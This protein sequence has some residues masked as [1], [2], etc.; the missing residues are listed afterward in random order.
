MKVCEALR[1][2]SQIDSVPK[3]HK[4]GETRREMLT[5]PELWRLDLTLGMVVPVP[6]LGLFM[7]CP[8]NT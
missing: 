1:T 4:Q 7:L 2:V 5:E 6:P 3:G 8:D